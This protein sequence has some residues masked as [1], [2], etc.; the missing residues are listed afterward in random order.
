MEQR[1]LAVTTSRDPGDEQEQKA[2]DLAH[3]LDIK[4]VSRYNI[5]LQEMFSC[6]KELLIVE[7]ERIIL[8]GKNGEFFFHPNM[9]KLRINNLSQ[10]HPDHLI[11]A[12]D[13]QNGDKL[14][15]CTLGLASDAIT[16]SYWV[17]KEGKVVGLEVSPLIYEI[18]AYGL[19]HCSLPY[20]EIEEAM[21]RITVINIHYLHY[22]KMLPDKS[23][24]AVYF[25]PMFDKTICGASSITPLRKIAEKESLSLESLDEAKRIARKRVV[26][27]SRKGSGNLESLGFTHSSTGNYSNVEYGYFTLQ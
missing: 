6:Y 19:A 4:Y 11:E 24:D 22:L 13:L 9:A 27:K 15:D 16:I 23:F 5:S 21:R 14:L 26:M 17:G 18:T 3:R 12:L 1:T 7:K 25:D 8:K 2:I 10:G 20:K